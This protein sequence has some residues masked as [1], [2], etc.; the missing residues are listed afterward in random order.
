MKTRPRAA[1]ESDIHP[2]VSPEVRMSWTPSIEVQ[3]LSL[4]RNPYTLGKAQAIHKKWEDRE[5]DE[6]TISPTSR[7]GRVSVKKDFGLPRLGNVASKY[8]TCLEESCIGSGSFSIGEVI[9][10]I[11]YIYILCL[12]IN[13]MYFFLSIYS[14]SMTTVRRAVHIETNMSVALKRISKRFIFSTSE[15]DDIIREIKLHISIRHPNIIRLHDA[16][17]TEEEVILVLDLCLGGNL[18]EISKAV[19]SGFNGG[20]VPENDARIIARALLKALQYL[21]SK[22]IMH[23]DVKPE[24]VLFSSSERPLRMNMV[25]LW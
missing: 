3:S 16:L 6:N 14:I 11:P 21:H 23:G 12:C 13:L 25:K 22:N 2:L 9:R 24:N 4:E 7:V 5:E 8:L 10:W 20:L 15:K 1:T 19:Y 17:E 18:R